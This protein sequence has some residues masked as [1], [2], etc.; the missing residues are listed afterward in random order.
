ME[1]LIMFPGDLICDLAGFAK[2]ADHRVVLRMFFNIIFWGA[3]MS[4]AALAVTL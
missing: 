2:D 4:G 1:R 3:A